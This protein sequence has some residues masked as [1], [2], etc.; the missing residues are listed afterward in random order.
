MANTG[1]LKCCGCKKQF[2]RETLIPINGSNYHSRQCAIEW[3]I[4]NQAKGRKKIKQHENKERIKKKKSKL[5]T[6]EAAAVLWCHRYI[7][8]RDAGKTCICCVR[9]NT[10]SSQAGHFIDSGNNSILRFNE[11]NINLQLK[12]CNYYRGGDSGEYENNLRLKIGDRKVD[13]LK[14]FKGSQLRGKPLKRTAEDYLIIEKYYKSK[15][16]KL[17]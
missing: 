16:N 17:H 11:N 7:R 6:R 5:K 4:A 8:A 1:P 9:P 10:E 3:A 12:H 13:Q 14:R 2:P 15:L